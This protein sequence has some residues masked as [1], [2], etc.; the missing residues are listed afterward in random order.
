MKIQIVTTLIASFLFIY[1]F[2]FKKNNKEK[3][4]KPALRFSENYRIII[5]VI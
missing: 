3:K 4:A 5:I 2:F 1:L